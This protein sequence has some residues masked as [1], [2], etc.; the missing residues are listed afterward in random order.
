MIDA[1]PV[2]RPTS[3]GVAALLA[4]LQGVAIVVV[5]ALEVVHLTPGRAT[6]GVTT[7]VFLVAY[8]A[9]LTFSAWGLS[10]CSSW[11]RGPVVMAQLID[12]GLAWNVRESNTPLSVGLTLLAVVTLVAVLVRPSRLA[13]EGG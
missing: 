6:M 1:G 3:L 10:R 8:G 9:G 13:L 5:A 4:G 7:A 11:A 12:L 2:R